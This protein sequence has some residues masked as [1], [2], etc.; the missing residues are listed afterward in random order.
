M[1]GSLLI[2]ALGLTS[3]DDVSGFNASLGLTPEGYVPWDDHSGAERW[4]L[5]SPVRAH[6]HGVR[7]LN[8]WV[9]QRFRAEQLRNGRQPW[10]LTLGDE[11]I[12][13]ADKVI[14][15]R[16]GKTDGWAKGP[17]EEYLANGEVGVMAFKKGQAVPQRLLH[18][19]GRPTL[20]LSSVA[21]SDWRQRPTRTGLRADCP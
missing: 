15:T 5:L 6:P 20:R 9:Q 21:V 2:S 13:T 18:R 12:V 7:D 4:Q 16:N 14:L 8:R 19:S 1:L 11:E 3:P 10:G 17:I